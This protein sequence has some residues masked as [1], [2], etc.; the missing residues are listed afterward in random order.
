MVSTEEQLMDLLRECGFDFTSNARDIAVRFPQEADWGVPSFQVLPFRLARPFAG[1]GEVWKIPLNRGVEFDLPPTQYFHEFHP[2]KDARSNFD[3]ALEP[4]TAL[5]GPGRSGTST[6]V[7][8][9]T[10]PIGFFTIRVISWPRELNS[11]FRNSYEGHNPY[12]WISAKV[13]IEPSF[14]FV[15]PGE[16][17]GAPMH[18]LLVSSDTCR[19]ICDS[20]VYARRNRVPAPPATL[21]AGIAEGAL[22]IRAEDRT[23]RV[24]LEQIRKVVLT[25]ITP[26]R[27][28]GSSSI[29]ID[30]VFLNRHEVRISIAAGAK[31]QSLDEIASRFARA[32]AKPF[33]VEECPDD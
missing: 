21:V 32:I 19:L 16:D 15:H 31:T 20:Q 1:F 11:R 24:P 10:W 30:T 3:Q 13:Y 6:N 2:T 7:Y 4:L 17:A 12:L 25:R 26:G 5:L 28:A 33:A 18:E 23:V 14:P 29:S 9:R 22:L 27:S 8:E